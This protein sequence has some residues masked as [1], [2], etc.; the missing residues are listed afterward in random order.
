MENGW[1]YVPTDVWKMMVL[2]WWK[3]LQNHGSDG[4]DDGF[5]DGFNV[6][7]SRIPLEDG[8]KKL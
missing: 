8:W 7:A 6:Y 3:W 2:M 5:D 4:F 1:F